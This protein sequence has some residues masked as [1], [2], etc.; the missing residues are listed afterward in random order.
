MEFLTIKEAMEL[1]GKA[2]GT[3]RTFIKNTLESDKAH[4][5]KKEDGAYYIDKGFLSSKYITK[6]ERYDPDM[7][8]ERTQ[9]ERDEKVRDL[10]E[11]LNDK[12]EIIEFLKDQLKEKD[13]QIKSIHLALQTEQFKNLPESEKKKIK[14]LI[15]LDNEG[16]SGGGAV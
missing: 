7:G 2:D 10:M 8:K 15:E 13:N 12:N 3:I 11:R 14:Q 4:F 9:E 16:R 1:T 5:A 6:E